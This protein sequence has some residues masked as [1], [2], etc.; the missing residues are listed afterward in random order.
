MITS[1]KIRTNP[2]LSRQCLIR[3]CTGRMVQHKNGLF[4][5]PVLCHI[6]RTLY[7][8]G[9]IR[10][11][12]RTYFSRNVL[13]AAAIAV[14]TVIRSCFFCNIPNRGDSHSKTPS[15]GRPQPCIKKWKPK[16]LSTTWLLS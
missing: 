15:S 6:H 16:R 5:L 9:H 12:F 10:T 11:C 7:T 3:K 1:P 2:A 4:S 8:L 14:S 13:N